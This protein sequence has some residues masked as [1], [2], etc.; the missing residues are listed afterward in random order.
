MAFDS[1][2]KNAF[3]QNRNNNAN[4]TFSVVGTSIVH[5]SETAM[6]LTD[7]TDFLA[8]MDHRS[9][10]KLADQKQLR[11]LVQDYLDNGG[12][13]WV[14]KACAKTKEWHV[15]AVQSTQSDGTTSPFWGVEYIA[16]D[17]ARFIRRREVEETSQINVGD[18]SVIDPWGD[19]VGEIKS[20]DRTI[21]LAQNN[22]AIS[23]NNFQQ[24]Y[25]AV[26]A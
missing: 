1:L 21:S 23:T 22:R 3:D 15:K 14:S 6:F 7:K 18:I 2:I 26:A 10:F 11:E 4:S 24:N 17:I 25:R 13:L 16:Q 9:Y 5:D 12:T 8:A 19:V 20:P